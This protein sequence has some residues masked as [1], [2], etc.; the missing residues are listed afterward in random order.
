MH[1]SSP[2]RANSGLKSR[3]FLILNNFYRFIRMVGKDFALNDAKIIKIIRLWPIKIKK[4]VAESLSH[5]MHGNDFGCI[6]ASGV[7]NKWEK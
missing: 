7:L 3:I 2:N 1:A 6:W 5:K 4:I